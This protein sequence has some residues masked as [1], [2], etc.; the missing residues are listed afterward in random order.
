MAVQ[1]PLHSVYYSCFEGVSPPYGSTLISDFG[2]YSV[3][4][5][6]AAQKKG[7]DRERDTP[8]AEDGDEDEEVGKGEE[9][10]L[11]RAFTRNGIV[12]E[13][14]GMRYTMRISLRYHSI[15]ATGT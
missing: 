1:T 13:L 5:S 11:A 8:E 15:Q 6:V 14:Q 2:T 7:K 9:E 10:A 12:I 4:T 3:K